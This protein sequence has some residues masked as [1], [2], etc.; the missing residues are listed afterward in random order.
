MAELFFDASQIATIQGLIQWFDA[1]QMKFLFWM[2]YLSAVLD[3]LGLPNLKTLA[4][5]VWRRIKAGAAAS[6]P[7]QKAEEEQAHQ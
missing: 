3:D 7:N 2:L 1:N 4:K 5:R 6:R